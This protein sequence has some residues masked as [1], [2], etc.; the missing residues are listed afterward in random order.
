MSQH[1]PYPSWIEATQP[2]SEYEADWPKVIRA[3]RPRIVAERE[4]AVFGPIKAAKMFGEGLY[5]I[6]E[7]PSPS[8]FGPK[9]PSCGSRRTKR[10]AEGYPLRQCCDCE[11]SSLYGELIPEK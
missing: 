9:C 11:R 10:L 1:W 5:A 2:L 7:R 8:Y 3:T 6:A 4:I